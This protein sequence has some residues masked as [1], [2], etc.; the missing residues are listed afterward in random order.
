MII[1]HYLYSPQA[2]PLSTVFVIQQ[3]YVQHQGPFK[4]STSLTAVNSRQ[5]EG[6]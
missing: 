3:C 6:P 1:L 2:Q 5:K 4:L